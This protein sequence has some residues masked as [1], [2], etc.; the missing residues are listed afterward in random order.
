VRLISG[1]IK[2]KAVKP[3]AYEA[4]LIPLISNLDEASDTS[5]SVLSPSAQTGYRN[6]AACFGI[7]QYPERDGRIRR[8]NEQQ[9][10]SNI[11]IDAASKIEV[12]RAPRNHVANA[13]PASV[14]VNPRFG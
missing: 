11:A 13:A 5:G 1:H 4:Y 10:S 3:R 7:P 6:G 12:I 9:N 14:R 8:G 2:P